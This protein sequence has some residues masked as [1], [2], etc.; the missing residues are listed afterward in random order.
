MMSLQKAAYCQPHILYTRQFIRIDTEKL[1]SNFFKH[2]GPDGRGKVRDTHPKDIT[3]NP[4]DHSLALLAKP[5]FVFVEC[6]FFLALWTRGVP[7]R[8]VVRYR[9]DNS[10]ERNDIICL[11]LCFRNV[12]RFIHRL[13]ALFPWVSIIT[14]RT[15]FIHSE[16][17][18]VPSLE[19]QR[20]LGLW[21]IIDN[22][23]E[24]CTKWLI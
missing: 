21:L 14:Q 8:T 18:F 2:A 16:F 5:P 7:N 24:R 3:V 20:F 9:G 6:H 19:F 22:R 11:A 17:R 13:D 23:I 12:V 10:G 1:F 15:E 4:I